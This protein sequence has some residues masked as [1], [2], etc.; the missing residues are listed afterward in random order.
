M[1]DGTDGSGQAERLDLGGLN[2]VG[3]CNEGAYMQVR[4]PATGRTLMGDDG[5]PVVIRLLGAD[6]DVYQRTR[7]RTQ[8]KR[9]K[10]SLQRGRLT[11]LTS[12]M[13]AEDSLDLLVA[14]T[15]GWSSNWVFHGETP[16]CEPATIRRVY[17]EMPW[18]REQV[19]EFIEDRAN[20]LGN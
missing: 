4:H 14:C 13:L 7:N 15:V 20:F 19:S 12:D 3:A 16:E 2:T 11:N 6:S 18:L 1:T 5:K 8:D 9:L 10:Q 17:T